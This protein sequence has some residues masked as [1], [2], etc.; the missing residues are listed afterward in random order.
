MIFHHVFWSVTVE[1]EVLVLMGRP[2]VKGRQT[3]R[4]LTHLQGCE[5]SRRRTAGSRCS[6]PQRSSDRKKKRTKS[7]NQLFT[8]NIIIII[9]II[10]II[11]GLCGK[12]RSFIY[13]IFKLL[14]KFLTTGM[15]PLCDL[16][17]PADVTL[18][19]T[20]QNDSVQLS[21]CLRSRQTGPFWDSLFCFCN[22]QTQTA[23]PETVK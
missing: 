13:F 4:S 15:Q 10:I 17:S 5:R 12:H 19:R 2:E 8:W 14:N 1:Q 23:V 18:I 6:R 20:S 21:F 9:I 16:I 3:A 22:L 7:L 11:P